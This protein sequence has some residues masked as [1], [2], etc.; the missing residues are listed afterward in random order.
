VESLRGGDKLR[1][2]YF[3]RIKISDTAC[4]GIACNEFRS[5][6][7]AFK[8]DPWVTVF[9]PELSASPKN[10]RKVISCAMPKKA[11]MVEELKRGPAPDRWRLAGKWQT[12]SCLRTSARRRSD[13]RYAPSI[14]EF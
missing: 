4:S 8:L 3:A 14:A 6:R 5:Y 9:I 13:P 10:L 12:V 2:C 1:P 7:K 11:T